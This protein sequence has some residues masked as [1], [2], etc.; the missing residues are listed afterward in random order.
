MSKKEN[1]F[2]PHP[3][4][5]IGRVVSLVLIAWWLGGLVMFPHL[6]NWTFW[7]SGNQWAHDRFERELPNSQIHLVGWI[8]LISALIGTI[9]LIRYRPFLI[10]HTH[11]VVGLTGLWFLFMGILAIEADWGPLAGIALSLAFGAGVSWWRHGE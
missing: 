2:R 11:T 9:L 1:P 10:R 6:L 8:W 5:P 3:P 7:P 4:G